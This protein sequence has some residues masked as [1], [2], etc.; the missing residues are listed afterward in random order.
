M[1]FTY[2]SPAIEQLRGIKVEEALS[3]KLEKALTPESLKLVFETLQKNISKFTANPLA[4]NFQINQIQQPCKDGSI[5]WVEVST[6]LRYNTEGAIEVVGVSRNIDDRKKMENKIRRSEAQLREL[7][8]TKDKFF[9]I[10]AHDLRGPFASM[11]SLSELLADE[12]IVLTHDEI[13]DFSKS[14]YKTASSTYILLENL[15]EWSLL[16]HGVIKF[17]QEKIDL[18]QFME[19]F[20]RSLIEMAAKKAVNFSI[21]VPGNM[22]ITADTNMLQTI[23]RNLVANAIKFTEKGGRVELKAQKSDPKIV[24]FVITDTGIGMKHEILENL[25]RIDKNVSRP[26]TNGEPSTGLGLILCKE[27]VDKH[28]GKIWAESSTGKGSV[29]TFTIPNQN[30]TQNG[31]KNQ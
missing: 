6:K 10:I 24:Q 12:K 15:L 22:V 5:I 13:V 28:G 25:F 1:K 26:G 27:F 20:D 19:N 14:L 29:F 4:P 23:L 3:E 9:S 16:Q 7:N 21:S 11:V 31:A 2:I 17:N 8:A 30:T 18:N